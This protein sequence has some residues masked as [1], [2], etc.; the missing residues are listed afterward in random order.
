MA[1]PVAGWYPDPSGNTSRTRF[2]DGTDWTDYYQYIS[3]AVPV[4]GSTYDKNAGTNQ[5]ASVFYLQPVQVIKD[6]RRS[7]ILALV[8]AIL[9]IVFSMVS[10]F[11]SVSFTAAGPSRPPIVEMVCG[12]LG[13]MSYLLITPTLIFATHGLQ[14]SKR[15]LSEIALTLGIIG[16]VLFVLMY[17]MTLID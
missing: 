14:S 1:Y 4:A 10:I 11:T 8:L 6:N 17:F 13:F 15:N 7:A 12:A 3:W 9:G 5:L 16:N 2:W